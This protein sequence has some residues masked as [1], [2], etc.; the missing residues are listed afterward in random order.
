MGHG[1]LPTNYKT[2]HKAMKL[3]Y[4]K[5]NDYPNDPPGYEPRFIEKKI[6]LLGVCIYTLI[7]KNPR[8]IKC[9]TFNAQPDLANSVQRQKNISEKAVISRNPVGAFYTGF[10]KNQIQLRGIYYKYD[11]VLIPSKGAEIKFILN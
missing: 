7:V 4:T 8:W 6:Y 2:L 11:L 5:F 9:D 3:F 1:A 10:D